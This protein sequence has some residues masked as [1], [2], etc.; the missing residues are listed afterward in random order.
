MRRSGTGGGRGFSAPS[1]PS[2]RQARA[3]EHPDGRGRDGDPAPAL[4]Q[5]LPVGHPFVG[6]M[7]LN[8][9]GE[10]VVLTEL[11]AGQ[12]GSPWRN[13]VNGRYAVAP[14]HAYKPD[15]WRAYKA[16]LREDPL[17][18]APRGRT[19]TRAPSRA[20]TTRAASPS[21]G[22]TASRITTAKSSSWN[23]LATEPSIG[24]FA[25]EDKTSHSSSGPRGPDLNDAH[26]TGA[27]LPL[28]ATP[29]SPEQRANDPL[30][31]DG[32]AWYAMHA[33]TPSG[34][35]HDLEHQWYNNEV[36]N[37]GGRSNILAL[38]SGKNSGGARDRRPSVADRVRALERQGA[39]NHAPNASSPA[40]IAR[41][42][43][44][45]QNIRDPLHLPNPQY[46]PGYSHTI[47][48]ENLHSI[49]I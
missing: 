20:L 21:G 29:L 4:D 1:N 19:R 7:G 10:E 23:L 12:T 49:A 45:A 47:R 22:S 13:V 30:A 18:S 9:R 14:R 36:S 6:C 17:A 37:L 24:T 34:S 5:L 26:K 28:P 2:P 48:F 35:V 31:P 41:R 16:S 42:S 39:P 8:D 25:I 46:N 27:L 32:A 38:D 44:S 33:N 15:E 40:P 43:S 3:A 11:P